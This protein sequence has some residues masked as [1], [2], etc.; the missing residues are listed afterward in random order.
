MI[1][2]LSR[3]DKITMV[4]ELIRMFDHGYNEFID[5]AIST[6]L[7]NNNIITEHDYKWTGGKEV[8]LTAIPEV[9][10]IK[11]EFTDCVVGWFGET[12]KPYT[13][14]ARLKALRKLLNYL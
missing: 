6:Y 13:G 8:T 4:N 3:A 10:K 11:P 2:E 12:D 14:I 1:C 5:Y 7:Y 9:V